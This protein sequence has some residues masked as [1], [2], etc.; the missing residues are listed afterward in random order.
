[1]GGAGADSSRWSAD[2]RRW[3][4]RALALARRGL[5]H[6]QPNPAVGCVVVRGD[7]VVGQGYHHRAGEPHAEVLALRDAGEA[8][9]DATLYVTL[10]PCNHH[11]RTPPCTDAILAA[12]IRRVKVASVDP[13]P[14]VAG[15]GIKRL[16]AAGLEVEVGLLEE[17]SQAL[18]PWYPTYV[19]R[20]RPWVHLKLATTLDGRLATRAG[21]A[22]WITAEKARRE[23]HRLRHLSGA[24]LVGAGTVRADDPA[25]T[26][27]GLRPAGGVHQPWR[28]VITRRLD[29][30]VTARL[31]SPDLPGRTVA[32]AGT[33]APREA[34]RRL[35]DR[36][37]DVWRI[38]PA[39][40]GPLPGGLDLG[41]LLRRLAAEGIASVLVEGGG[42][43]AASLLEGGW[44]DWISWYVAPLFIGDPRAVP[45]L[46]G[47]GSAILAEAWRIREG[48]VRRVGPDV[49]FEGVPA[50]GGQDPTSAASRGRGR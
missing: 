41:E 33:D 21:D 36:G 43:L 48:R 10:E 49:V 31:F 27:R 8:A 50:R 16:Q 17:E 19:T 20:G 13:N 46:S 6:T 11:G 24:V 1:M 22:R 42:T 29:L 7:Q 5:G 34:E 12:G 38:P 25:L 15:A 4:Q 3:M 23:V 26:V 35:R 45:A 44:V 9:R 28:V 47:R 39:R 32:V 14:R 37:V 30:P 18:N 2:D 40:D